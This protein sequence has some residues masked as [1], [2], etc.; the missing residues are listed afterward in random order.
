MKKLLLLMLLCL[1]QAAVYAQD[2]SVT[3]KGV[4]QDNKGEA[5]MGAVVIVKN[6]PGLGSSTDIN[7][8]FKITTGKFEV[9]EVSYLGFEK[10][11]V[12][13][14]SIKDPENVVI[15]LEEQ[16]QKVDE[17]VVTAS[18]TQKK[19]TVTGAFTTVDVK[20]LN[21]PSGNLSNSL[22]G[23]VPGIIT[24][25]LSGEP[26][27]NQSDFWIRGISTFGANAS[28][29]VLVDGIERSL[30]EIPVE[31]IESFSVLKDASATAVYGNRGANGVVLI[32]TKKGEKGKIR[33][34]GKLQY[35]YNQTG[36]LPEYA[37]AI[38]YARLANEAR[39]ARYQSPLYS[40][41]ELYIIQNNL[42]PDLYPNVDWQ[43]LM[44]KDGASQY[45]A[46]LSFTGGGDNATYYVSGAYF[47]E[48][49][50]YRTRSAENKYNTNSTYERYNY[51]ANTTMNITRTTVLSVGIG[52]YLINRTQPGSTSADIWQ[53][54]SEY[55]P[56]TTPRKW[57]TGQWPIVNG[58]KTPEFLMTQTG[59]R[60]IWQNK[61]ETN[62]SLDQKL[63]FITKGLTFSGTFAFDTW[64]DNTITRSKSP[65]LWSAQNYRDG[66]GK[67]ILKR[68]QDVQPMTQS[69]STSGTKRYYLQAKLE[70]D[71]LFAK[72]HQVNGLLMVYQEEN[73]DT[74]LGSDIIASIPKRNLAYSGQVRYAFKS[75]YLF[76]FNFGY[77]GSENFEKGKQFGFFPAFSAGWVIS[78][79]PWVRK[80]LPWLEFFKVRGS[81]GEVGN[82]KIG[83][84]TRFPYIS[85]ISEVDASGSY[86]F[87]QFGSNYI[88][89]YRM[90]TVGTPNLTWEKATKWDIGVDWSIF[91]GM[92]TGTV[93]YFRDNRDDIFM[94]RNNMPLSTGL[95]DQTPMANV[96]RMRSYGFDGNIAFNHKIGEVNF[97]LRAN[98][99]YQNTEILDQDEA[100]NEFWYKM[101]RGF[102]QGQTRGFI[103]LG[104]F[105]DEED[106]KQS[107][108]QDALANFPIMPGDIKYKDVNGDGVITEDDI[109]PIGYRNVPGLI[110]GFGFSAAWRNFGINLLFQ[111]AG[112]RTFFVGGNGPHA[113]HDGA[114]GNILQ[115]MVEEDRWIPSDISGTKDTENPNAPWPR[116][117]Y[118]NNNN[119]NRASTYWMKDGSYLRLKNLEITYD[120][121]RE[122]IQHIR[123]TG[124]R[125]GFIGENLFT[126][127]PFKWWD[128]EG[129]NESGNAYPISRT[130]SFYLSFNL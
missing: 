121:P 55:T 122:I 127:S 44:L 38:D 46:Q 33:I 2:N 62:V 124:L 100:A 50:I 103:A 9:L 101:S 98:M 118:T 11:E 17:V 4:V 27:E 113:F 97:T 85:L 40:D 52:G 78:E 65:E 10:K 105:K 45:R 116:L 87:G 28:A 99:T 23:V 107:P 120:V 110:Y 75:R 71:R 129:N 58:K 14:V 8:R 130:F 47:N 94:R 117:T 95:A 19:K 32:T 26:G 119:N 74:K 25:Q 112:K 56:L 12:P 102:R 15:V 39:L 80:A 90:T 125:L 79:E 64:N 57:S 60:T 88:T 30:N 6:Q 36:K 35:G 128:P 49:G 13:V 24:Q 126:W 108:S 18:G 86:A 5:I 59:Y 7:G 96:G 48:D 72:N 91:N 89:G 115:R 82:D 109:V 73:S 66:Y 77:T 29:L 31:D 84:D 41:E 21:A 22:G 43:D 114:T 106:I 67:L 20:Q 70:Y 54:F 76:E 37:S 1:V 63:D 42:D 93:D 3:V 104:L 16:S 68:E 51:R 92:F 111:G 69:S 61:M 34:S 83:G 53:A 81:W 123:L